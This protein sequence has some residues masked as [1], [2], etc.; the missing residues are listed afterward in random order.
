M[1]RIFNSTEEFACWIMNIVGCVGSV[2]WLIII[3]C[4]RQESTAASMSMHRQLLVFISSVLV[5][6]E[7]LGPNWSPNS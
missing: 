4:R 1:I 6:V 3:S 7:E 5:R 2:P